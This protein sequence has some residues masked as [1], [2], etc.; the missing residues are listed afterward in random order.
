MVRT[1]GAIVVTAVLTS[2]FWIFYYN[3]SNAPPVTLAGEKTTVNPSNEPP[4]AAVVAH[5]KPV[6][7]NVTQPEDTEQKG[8]NDRQRINL[9]VQPD[10]SRP[11][12]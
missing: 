8:D 3:V 2:A 9:K 7:A 5:D 6:Q 4:V 10:T 11:I 12:E 1:F